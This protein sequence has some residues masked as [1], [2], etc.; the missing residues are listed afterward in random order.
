MLSIFGMDMLFASILSKAIAVKG[1]QVE[2]TLIAGEKYIVI[3]AIKQDGTRIEIS[4]E[5][6][7]N[8]RKAIS[9]LVER[10]S[11]LN[12]RAA[13][14]N[15]SGECN[16]KKPLYNIMF[17]MPDLVAKFG[18]PF[19]IT[20]TPSVDGSAVDVIVSIRY[21]DEYWAKVECN[22]NQMMDRSEFSPPPYKAS[23]IGSSHDY[24]RK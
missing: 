23:N 12:Y 19:S 16:F 3:S 8:V 17:T 10:H 4:T 18:H 15:D 6:Y 22:I 9:N 1:R 24:T 11:R 14:L 5:S 7:L 13:Y 2:F 20:S 21:S